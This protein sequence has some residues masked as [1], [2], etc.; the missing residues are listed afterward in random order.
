[1]IKQGQTVHKTELHLSLCLYVILSKLIDKNLFLTKFRFG[2]G[3]RFI[4][5][6]LSRK[7]VTVTHR[8]TKYIIATGNIYKY[9]VMDIQSSTASKT[10]KTIHPIKVCKY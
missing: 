4:S 3:V 7:L 10:F 9:L 6:L 1:M 8:W 2:K 5:Q